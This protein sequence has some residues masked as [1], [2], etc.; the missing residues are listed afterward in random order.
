MDLPDLAAAPPLS[1]AEWD[2]VLMAAALVLGRRNAGLTA[3]NPAVGALLVRWDAH[4]RPVVIAR[5]WTARGG[6]PHAER[7][8]LAAAGP[9]ARG[10]TAYVTLEPCSHHGAT[11]PCSDALVAAGVGEVVTAMEDPNPAVAGRGHAALAAA[12]IP[13][14]TGVLAREAA[15]DHAGHVRRMRSGRPHA[16]L[17]MAVSADGCI[18]REG[19]GQVAISGARSRREAHLM[20][21]LSDAILVGVGTVLS[22]D[23]LL[24]CR[25]PGLSD[26]SPV[27]VVLDSRLA[28]PPDCRLVRSLAEAPVIAVAAHPADARRRAALEAA[29]V[30]VLE[31]AP[32][33]DGRL[34]LHAALAAL[35]ARGITTVMV[36]GGARIASALYAAG[37]VD[38]VVIVRAPL[39]VGAG[40]IPALA[41]HSV[42][43]LL[44]DPAYET[45]ATR[46]LGPDRLVRR[47]RR[48]EAAYEGAAALPA[49][50]NEK[51]ET[52]TCSL[53]S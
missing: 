26:R 24:T 11:T 21:A 39:R 14:T 42:E 23:P 40:G 48:G 8:A 12:G 30:T 16:R 35:A 29:G 49:E 20:R 1:R 43:A 53:A 3:P 4:G 27:R 31:V 38:E 22:D 5:G 36:E 9:A 18:G 19:A 45:I 13:V 10:A 37:L 52:R 46:V 44:A 6:R 47:V 51:G 28:M 17:K 15:I 2:R 7:N 34:D 33:A 41:A 50:A 32:G 25:L